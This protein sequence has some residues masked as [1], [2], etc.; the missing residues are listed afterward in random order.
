MKRTIIV[1]LVLAA[2]LLGGCRRSITVTGEDGSRATVTKSGRNVEI[3]VE[4]KSGGTVQ[5]AGDGGSVALPEGFPKDVPIYAGAKVLTS[6][7]SGEAMHVTL[8]TSDAASTVSAFYKEQVKASGWEIKTTI[9]QPDATT[10]MC[11]KEKSGLHVMVAG[12][13]DGTM[14]NLTVTKEE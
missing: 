8:Q 7:K 13:N 12:G 11:A 14:V 5:I 2:G 1:S 3:K 4:G 6:M 9:D 10:L